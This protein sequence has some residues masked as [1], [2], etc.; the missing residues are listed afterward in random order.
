MSSLVVSEKININKSIT[1]LEIVHAH[2]TVEHN[3]IYLI[4]GK[5]K[6][7][8]VP[9]IDHDSWTGENYILRFVIHITCSI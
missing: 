6:L 1:H 9:V 4:P 7:S 5:Q 3:S 8:M 2:I